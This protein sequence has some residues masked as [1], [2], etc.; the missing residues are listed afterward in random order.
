MRFWYFED[1]TTWLIIAQLTRAEEALK[2]ALFSFRAQL[3]RCQGVYALRCLVKKEAVQPTKILRGGGV[4]AGFTRGNKTTVL[5]ACFLQVRKF[6]S[7]S[8]RARAFTVGYKNRR[9]DEERRTRACCGFN[10]VYV[11]SRFRFPAECRHEIRVARRVRGTWKNFEEECW[12]KGGK[13][14]TWV[15]KVF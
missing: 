2:K 4:G 9:T 3:K 10:Q 13:F 11:I 8:R 6:K 15:P 7:S 1:E 12:T 14:S 5:R